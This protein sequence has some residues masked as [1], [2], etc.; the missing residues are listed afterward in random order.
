MCDWTRVGAVLVPFL[1]GHTPVLGLCQ[2][3]CWGTTYVH[4]LIPIKHKA[5]VALQ[6]A[7]IASLGK[8]ANLI[9]LI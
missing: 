2:C 4:I 8:Q 7:R 5:S 3:R 9:T 1:T 6:S